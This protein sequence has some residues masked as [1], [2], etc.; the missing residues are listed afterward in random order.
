MLEDGLRNGNAEKMDMRTIVKLSVKRRTTWIPEAASRLRNISG[1]VAFLESFVSEEKDMFVVL[2]MQRLMAHIQ[3]PT[4]TRNK[5]KAV[6][7]SMPDE[8]VDLFVDLKWRNACLHVQELSLSILE[9]GQSCLSLP[10]SPSYID[11]TEQLEKLENT[12]NV[13]SVIGMDSEWHGDDSVSTLQVAVRDACWVID[14]L[15]PDAEY[16]ARCRAFIRSL[17]ACE[18]DNV[19]LGFAVGNDLPRLETYLGETLSTMKLLDLQMVMMLSS[20]A[21]MPGLARC[22]AEFSS[23]PLSKEQQCSDWSQRPLTP[24]QVEYAGLDAAVLPLL[25]AEKYNHDMSIRER[26]AESHTS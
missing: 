17:F 1:S 6:D 25:L 19:L 7:A 24:E 23:V 10:K 26:K 15:S 5:S 20:R 12:L 22:V 2:M 3:C 8:P 18:T 21:Q 4:P 11:T 13:E 9:N 14:L 16:Q